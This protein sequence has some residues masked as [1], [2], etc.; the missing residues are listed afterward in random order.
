MKK[1][2][3]TNFRKVIKSKNIGL[4][5]S[6]YQT[7]DLPTFFRGLRVKKIVPYFTVC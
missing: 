1:K 2:Q 6:S 5:S 4:F 7:I 3:L